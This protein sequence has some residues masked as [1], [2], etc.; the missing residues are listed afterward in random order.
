MMD[1]PWHTYWRYPGDSGMATKIKWTL[2]PGVTAGEIRWPLPEKKLVAGLVGFV[3]E[4]EIVLPVPLTLASNLAAGPLEI[5]AHA[6]WLECAELCVPGETNLTAHFVVG[7]TNVI[8]AAANLISI[9]QQAVPMTVPT[10]DLEWDAPSTNDLRT[11][12][13]QW[14]DTMPPAIVDYFPYAADDFE[15]KSVTLRSFTNQSAVARFTVKKL[16]ASWPTN[17]SGLLRVNFSAETNAESAIVETFEANFHLIEPAAPEVAPVAAATPPQPA[18]P[19]SLA[20]NLMLALLGG[21]LLNLM[22]CVLPVIALKILGFVSQAGENPKRIRTLGIFY[23]FGVLASF[24]VLADAV[25]A[26]QLAGHRASWGMQFSQPTFIVAL[27]ALVFLVALNLFGVFEFSVGARVSD[28]AGR[29]ASGHGASGAFW[30]GVLATV[31]ATP[32][33]APFLAPALGYAF[34]QPPLVVVLFFLTIG[35][36]LALPYLA[37]SWQPAWLK[38]L[39]KPGA[40]MGKF[41]FAMGIPMLATTV[42]L[43]YVAAAFYGDKIIWLA[44]FLI[45]LGAAAWIFGKQIQRG[46]AKKSA[47]L[48]CAVVLFVGW[49][50][51]LEHGLHWRTALKEM[52]PEPLQTSPEGIAWQPWSAR[53]VAAARGAGRVVL[54][55]FTA[56]WCTTCQVNKAVALEVA[57]VRARLKELHAVALL[58]DFTHFDDAIG[59]EL[60]RHNRAGVPLVLV[61]PA[62]TNLP[63]E[64]L[65][66]TLTPQIVLD[67]LNRGASAK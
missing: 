16:G 49:A 38:F 15:L 60:A 18:L 23:T 3:Y 54:V 5:K 10:I 9:H 40:W 62:N 33:T 45:F 28:A 32:C 44:G 20:F 57:A 22:P 55:D 19:E 4:K 61:Y 26:V 31:L 6:A 58:A 50:F 64:T 46:S 24:F 35:F 36:G 21:L 67:A 27:A 13:H 29:A 12:T 37:L 17:I 39:P 14:M 48:A 41:K 42:W 7:D 66:A 34:T 53:A 30:N 11:F 59:A 51:A 43:G 47:W 25:V 56:R 52:P 8:S 1:E 2:P 65:P 63:P